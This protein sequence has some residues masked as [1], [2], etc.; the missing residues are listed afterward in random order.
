MFKTPLYEVALLVAFIAH[1]QFAASKDAVLLQQ[2]HREHGC[3]RHW[4]IAQGLS[5]LALKIH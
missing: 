1:G 4:T 2:S 5:M 3:S